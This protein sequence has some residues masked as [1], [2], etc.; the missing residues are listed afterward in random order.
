M[1]VL[2]LA[3]NDFVRS[4]SPAGQ[5]VAAAC[6]HGQVRTSCPQVYDRIT[7]GL[8]GNPNSALRELDFRHNLSAMGDMSLTGLLKRRFKGKAKQAQVKILR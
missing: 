2:N 1:Q 3:S 4:V 8:E 7:S 5:D 6:P